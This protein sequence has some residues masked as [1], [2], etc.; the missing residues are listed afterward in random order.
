MLVLGISMCPSF[1]SVSPT[2]WFC[3]IRNSVFTLLAS[4]HWNPTR[5]FLS[6][7]N[8]SSAPSYT[9]IFLRFSL[10]P[11][12]LKSS[13]TC[14]SYS[15][16]QVSIFSLSSFSRIILFKKLIFNRLSLCCLVGQSLPW[17]SY[18]TFES[19]CLHFGNTT[20]VSIPSRG[21]AYL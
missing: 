16:S 11:L 2:L 3:L 4:V 13:N 17:V 20:L 12:C 21:V 19:L 14:S 9:A 15:S 10:L 5:L 1:P 18:H 8:V 6:V 7:S